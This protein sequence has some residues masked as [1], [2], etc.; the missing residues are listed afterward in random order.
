MLDEKEIAFVERVTEVD[1]W[2]KKAIDVEE[3]LQA[4]NKLLFQKDAKIE[5]ER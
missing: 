3:K 2:V 1:S 4:A 5:E